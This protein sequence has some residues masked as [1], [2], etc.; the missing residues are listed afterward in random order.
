M[1]VGV[2]VVASVSVDV[3]VVIMT[4]VTEM[5]FTTVVYQNFLI[6]LSLMSRNV[7]YET[8]YGTNR[9]QHHETPISL[10]SRGE[11][12]GLLLTVLVKVFMLVFGS[13]FV[14]VA[15]WVVVDVIVWGAG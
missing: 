4:L 3:A 11:W 14:E 2:L 15:N 13:V 8:Y 9:P 7:A 5:V 12:L 1:V 6:S 10:T